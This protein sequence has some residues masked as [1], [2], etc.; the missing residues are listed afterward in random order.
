MRLIQIVNMIESLIIMTKL[1]LPAK[2][3]FNLNNILITFEDSFNSYNSTKNNLLNQYGKS[4]NGINYDF[5]S[6][7]SRQLFFKELYELD[8]MDID[9][10]FNKIKAGLSKLEKFIEDEKIKNPEF[11]G[12]ETRH[13]Y[14]VKDIIEFYDDTL[15]E[16]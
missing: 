13:L 15:A 1:P 6:D 4:G 2:D 5:D 7:K 16:D 3:S 9:I 11:K 8:N 12:I 14:N 10:T